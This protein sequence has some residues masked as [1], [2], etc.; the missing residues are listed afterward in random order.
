MATPDS[1]IKN[2]TINYKNLPLVG[3]DGRYLFKFRV[4]SQD[5]A[6]SSEWSNIQSITM[7]A[8]STTFSFTNN[9]ASKVIPVPTK[10][11]SIATLSWA[12]SGDS[13]TLP[14]QLSDVYFDVFYKTGPTTTDAAF[15]LLPYIYHST[16]N[17]KTVSINFS[18]TYVKFYIQAATSTK[19]ISSVTKIF[20]S[21]I[22]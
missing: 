1:V 15:N 21:A 5:G 3:S 11:G 20:E 2:A 13:W 18:S 4:L 10:S 9:N 19:T 12:T 17:A 14:S 22:V 8:L 16:V 6:N 7:P